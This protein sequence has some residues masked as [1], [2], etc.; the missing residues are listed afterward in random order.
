MTSKNALLLIRHLHDFPAGNDKNTLKRKLSFGSDATFYRALRIARLSPGIVI[1]ECNGR[2]VLDTELPE[3]SANPFLPTDD[4]LI[5]LVSLQH[6]MTKMTSDTLR[7]LYEPLYKRIARYLGTI[8]KK[9]HDWQTRIKILDIHHRVIPE[10]IF[11]S[12]LLAT[13]HQHTMQFWYE[14]SRGKNSD[15]IVSPQQIVRYKDNWY[16]D[17]WCHTNSDLRIFSLDKITDL[18]HVNRK[19]IAAKPELLKKVYATSYGIF[20]GE[21]TNTAHIRLTGLAARYALREAW[22]PDQKRT[23]NSDN[24][25]TLEIPY[26][27]PEELIREIL[28]R[29][30]EAEVLA[31]P[32]LRKEIIAIIASTTARYQ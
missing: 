28:A 18:R 2:Y 20:S 7:T 23:T 24:S 3:P 26:R 19:F 13:M 11:S 14:D 22:H 32:E 15:R 12:L 25:V 9:Y 27:K 29:G 30:A 21:P 8:S 31:P 1:D 16:L 17:A 6:I 10:G 5:M 4:E